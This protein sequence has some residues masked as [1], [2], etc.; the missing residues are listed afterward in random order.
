MTGLFGGVTG[1]LTGVF[2]APVTYT[3]KNGSPRQVNAIFRAA[4]LDLVDEAGVPVR[5]IT[6]ILRVRR[7]DLPGIA[8][9]DRV[10]VPDG[11]IFMVQAVW[12]SGSPA[13]DAFHVCDLIEACE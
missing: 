7:S 5:S 11:R 13:D 4:P 6:P 12:P 9:G 2:G 10:T 3:P 8:R 1:L